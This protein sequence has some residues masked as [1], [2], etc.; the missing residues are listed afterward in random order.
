MNKQQAQSVL[1]QAQQ[2]N[3]INFDEFVAK[4]YPDRTDHS[5][6][7]LAFE[8]EKKYETAKKEKEIELLNSQNQL[9]AIELLREADIRQALERENFLMDATITQQ[10]ELTVLTER[11]KDL[12]FRELE[13]EK[14][15]SVSLVNENT[16]KE[17]LLA[18][19][20]NR[21]KLL[22]SGLANCRKSEA[23]CWGHFGQIRV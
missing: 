15:L 18:D 23:F 21:K 10:N 17:K 8:L 6:K 11:E 3:S 1:E 9:S 4:A 7:E 16:L 12:Q 2:I 19:D 5:N 20:K 14:Q 13:K 22:L